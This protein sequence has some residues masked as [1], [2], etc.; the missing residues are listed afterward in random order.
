MYSNVYDYRPKHP[1]QITLTDIV[2]MKRKILFLLLFPIMVQLV[3]SCCSCV[4][5]LIQHYS[6]KSISLQN[7]DN[8]GSEPVPSTSGSIAKTAYGIRLQVIR[9]KTACIQKQ[10]SLFITSAYAM[11]CDCPPLNQYIP[12]DSITSIKIYT[13]ND[14]DSSH[15]SNADISDYFKVYNLFSFSTINNYLKKSSSIL[16]DESELETK[17]DLLLMTPPI[18][19]TQHKFNIQITLSDGRIFQETLQI[20]LI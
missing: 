2:N 3:V 8:S 18:V 11:S 19:N 15:L 16:Y 10:T 5:P 4:E 1:V 14:F 12:K 6:N 20:E 13:L 7:L 17:A 9:E